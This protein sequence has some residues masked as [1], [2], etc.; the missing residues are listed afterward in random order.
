MSFGGPQGVFSPPRLVGAA[1]Q[2]PP[3]KLREA[4]V[5]GVGSRDPHP[6][7]PVGAPGWCWV[8]SGDGSGLQP[9]CECK[10]ASCYS[11]V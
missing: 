6:V 9:I 5:W 11:D 1:P 10:G 3:A 2:H 4:R 7:H 8:G